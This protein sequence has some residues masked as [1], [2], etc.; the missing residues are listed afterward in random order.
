MLLP[1]LISFT[2]LGLIGFGGGPSMIPLIQHEVVKSRR[3][4]T[5]DE[6]GNVLAIANSLPGPIATKLPGY[7]GFRVAGLAGCLASV[8]AITLPMVLAMILLLDLYYRF[9]EYS[10]IQGMGAGILPVVLIMMVQLA[11]DFWQ[12]SRKDFGWKIALPMVGIIG[13][14]L[15]LTSLHPAW[16]VGAILLAAL[17]TPAPRPHTRKDK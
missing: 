11:W 14:I 9:R 6:F 1:L 12:K 4:M 8:L 17:I 7:I 10:W 16:V 2:K 5:D 15:S 13:L 3:W